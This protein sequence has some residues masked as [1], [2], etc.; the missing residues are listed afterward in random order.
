MIHLDSCWKLLAAQEEFVEFLFMVI[1]MAI[2]AL[3]GML[4]SRS[5]K[6]PPPQK[7]RQQPERQ[8][9]PRNGG[10]L[11]IRTPRVSDHHDPRI[12]TDDSAVP[13]ESSRP[14]SFLEQ[15][16]RTMEDKVQPPK[17]TAPVSAASQQKPK[18]RVSEER[19]SRLKGLAESVLKQPDTKKARIYEC[20]AHLEQ[21]DL[22]QAII[23]KEILDRPLALREVYTP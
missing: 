19:V 5:Q 2:M 21:D 7:M 10:N 15:I 22:R 13:S 17:Q 1:V 12:R 14:R 4:K 8:T 3:G 23:L 20:L 18:S 16:V 11:P 6:K 9:S